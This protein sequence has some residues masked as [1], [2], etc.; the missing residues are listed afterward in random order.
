MEDTD[1]LKIYMDGISQYGLLSREEEARLAQKAQAGDEEAKKQLINS[2]LRLVVKI[3]H[4]FKGHGVPLTDLISEGNLGLIKAVGMFDPS[5]GAKLSSYAAWWIKQYMRRAIYNQSPIVRIPT[6]NHI[7][8]LHVRAAKRTLSAELGRE[9]TESEIAERLNL[10]PRMVANAKNGLTTT[11][12]LDAEIR[13]GEDSVYSE[14]IA[15]PT[16]ASPDTV[17]I[18][19]E[20]STQIHS[21]TEV[22]DSRERDI[23][24]MRFGLDGQP[25]MT[26]DEVS[27]AIGR[28]RERVRQLQNS[29]LQKL[30]QLMT[31]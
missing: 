27:K 22:L 4:D 5:K 7:K 30:K 31:E 3:A 10:T 20:L 2:N 21:L 24:V 26:L 15:D 8:A 29:A 12:Y 17:A 13:N 6:Q 14:I 23:I 28:T 9:P 16:S 1:N 19:Q 18:N 11:I 25:P